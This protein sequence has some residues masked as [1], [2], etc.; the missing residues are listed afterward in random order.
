M[1]TSTLES[2]DPGARV[3]DSAMVSDALKQL[4][5]IEAGRQDIVSCYLRLEPTDRTAGHYLTELK[6]RIGAL[7][8][9]TLSRE[10]RMAVERDL[11]RIAAALED[12][13]ALP[14]SR[15]VALFACEALDLLMVMP[16]PRV[17]RTRVVVDDTPWLLELVAAERDLGRVLVVAVNRT[18]ARVFR[19]SPT[20]SVELPAPVT[21]A[22]RGGKYSLDRE[23][24]PGW[25]EHRYHNRLQAERHRH[26]AAIVDR[27]ESLLAVTPNRG[28]LLAGPVDQTSALRRFLP[29]RLG[30]QLLGTRRVNPRAVTA[31]EIQAMALE[32]AAQ[33]RA[34]ALELLL[35]RVDNTVASGWAVNGAR[36]TLRALAAG[37]V[38]A[39]IVRE[40]L[41]GSGYRCRDTGRL[42]LAK[43]DCSGEGD[44]D[45][46]RDIVD[47]AVEDA[48]RQKADVEI[49]SDPALAA[50]VDGLAALLRF[51]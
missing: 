20:E 26:Y 49:V 46:V 51:R 42:V 2:S 15:G 9:A 4:V 39:L 31:P 36:E 38:R 30:R 1:T 47:E 32:S 29:P 14:H 7:D 28:F 40:D 45:P 44:P 22:R 33:H 41:S 43:G 21:P 3:P 23:D 10:R 34:K 5:T 17:H 8:L 35:R 37:Q 24:A 16:L 13:A 6:T 27:L 11:D 25:G 48:L 18:H 50:S 19:V 12:P